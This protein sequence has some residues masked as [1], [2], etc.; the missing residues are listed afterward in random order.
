MRSTTHSKLLVLL[1]NASTDIEHIHVGGEQCI[2]RVLRNYAQPPSVALGSEE[3]GIASRFA[4]TA[5]SLNCRP[6]FPIPK[7][8]SGVVLIASCV[9]LRRNPKSLVRLVLVDKKPG[10]VRNVSDPNELNEG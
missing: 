8:D 1:L 3:F 10:R 9:V 6:D 7:L 2:T 5:V 4:Y